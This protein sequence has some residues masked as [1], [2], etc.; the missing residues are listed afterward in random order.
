MK[1]YRFLSIV[2]G[3][4]IFA[5]PIAHASDL[6]QLY[7]SDYETFW[8]Q[9]SKSKEKALTC[10]DHA[11][12][13]KFLSDAIIMLRNAEVSEA[14]AKVIEKLCLEKPKCLLETLIKMKTEEQDKLVRFFIT[15]PIF[16]EAAEIKAS[17]ERYWNLPRYQKIRDLYSK[18][19]QPS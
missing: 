10:K 16:H 1:K 15:S 2:F 18:M 4:Y 8:K 14:N 7:A 5:I 12:M 13:P 9:W 19:K 6:D 17:L 3:L 11:T